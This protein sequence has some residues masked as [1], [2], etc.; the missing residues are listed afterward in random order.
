MN[1]VCIIQARTTSN[2]LP[3]KV[4]LNLP[5]ASN[6]T[7]LEQVVERIK[8]SK[9]INKIF[10]A[11]TRNNTDDQIEELCAKMKVDCYRGS[12]ED[13]LS[14]YY[15][16][17]TKIQADHIIRITSDCPCI[18]YEVIDLLIEFHL[19]NKNDF[20]SNNQIHSFPH[21]MDC[22]IVTYQALSEAFDNSTE[23]YEREHVMPYI[24]KSHPDKY[25]IGILQDSQNNYDIRITL[26]TNEDYILLC[27]V[28]DFLYKRNNFFKKKEIVELFQD[29]KYLYK[30][31]RNIEQKKVCSNLE[32]EIQEAKELLKKQDL[33]RAYD[34]LIE[35]WEKK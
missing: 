4:L 11:T 6:K 27:L 15:E 13:V 24:Y 28:Y 9:H 22:E 18:D 31:N 34:F 12:E 8:K 1:I 35:N 7:V 14:R 19:K 29:K 32:E 25:K 21:G 5:Y 17:A 3:N 23:K 20:S 10:I 2:R 26:D 30:I 33:N 16:V